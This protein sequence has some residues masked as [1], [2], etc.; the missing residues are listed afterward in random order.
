M[1]LTLEGI[2]NDLA[3]PL[4]KPNELLLCFD[5]LK[6][7]PILI[8]PNLESDIAPEN[9]IGL[10]AFGGKANPQVVFLTMNLNKPK[11][12]ISLAL[13]GFFLEYNRI[14]ISEFG[15]NNGQMDIILNC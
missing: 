12:I 2:H 5:L 8:G 7:M 9:S 15:H 11:D 10:Q 13:K 14:C 4:G 1:Q 6:I 3:N